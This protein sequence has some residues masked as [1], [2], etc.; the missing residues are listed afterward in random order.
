[1]HIVCI[2]KE[3]MFHATR[4]S[5]R[6]TV[7]VAR[8]EHNR[9]LKP[10]ATDFWKN[11]AVRLADDLPPTNLAGCKIIEV[12]YKLVVCHTS[13][14][15]L[16]PSVSRRFPI[17]IPSLPLHMRLS[18]SVFIFSINTYTILI[19]C[20]VSSF[21]TIHCHWLFALLRKWW[22]INFVLTRI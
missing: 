12:R 21:T 14:V 17:G 10:H 19:L 1:M 15:A 2:V 9:I 16:R 20:C 5:R 6:S 11:V 3:K 8:I 4:K 13:F 22:N 18:L 7:E